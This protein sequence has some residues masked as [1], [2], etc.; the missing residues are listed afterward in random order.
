MNMFNNLPKMTRPTNK[1]N[2]TV[3][4]VENLCD[5][6]SSMKIKYNIINLI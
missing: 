6:K 4:N 2:V 5:A 3:K 1:L